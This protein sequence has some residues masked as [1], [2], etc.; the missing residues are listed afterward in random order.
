MK[1][2]ELYKLSVENDCS[3][4]EIKYV[5]EGEEFAFSDAQSVRYSDRVAYAF[6][7]DLY[8]KIRKEEVVFV[9]RIDEII[10]ITEVPNY[11]HPNG[12]DLDWKQ[13][14]ASEYGDPDLHKGVLENCVDKWA[15]VLGLEYPRFEILKRPNPDNALSVYVWENYKTRRQHLIRM[16]NLVDVLGLA[17][18]LELTDVDWD[19]EPSEVLKVVR[20]DISAKLDLCLE[21]LK[22]HGIRF[23]GYD[24]A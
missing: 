4:Y 20:E 15:S 3:E 18:I 6:Y 10:Y 7:Y 12:F 9:D 17:E 16:T 14:K 2:S 24:L 23:K 1:L 8:D 13:Y 21:K 22:E 5:K 19:M 11:Y